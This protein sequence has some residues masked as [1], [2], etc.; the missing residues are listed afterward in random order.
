MDLNT[1]ARLQ[2]ANWA[3]HNSD[4][5]LMTDDEYDRGL[6]ELKRLAPSHPFLKLVGAPASAKSSVILP[7]TMGSQ[8]KVREG[9]GGL[10]RWVKRQSKEKKFIVSEKLDGL[11]ALLVIRKFKLNLYLRGDGV[12]GVDVSSVATKI[13]GCVTT[14]ECIVRG[15]LLLRNSDTPTGSIGRSLVNGWVHRG[16][17]DLASLANV[18]FVAYQVLEPAGLARGDQLRWLSAKGFEVPWYQ[19]WPSAALLKEGFLLNSLIKRKVL[20][21]YPLDGLVVATDSVPLCLGGGEA[22]NPPDSVAYKASLDEQKAETRVIGVEWNLSRQ[23]IWI[24]RIQIEP[25]QSG[26]ATIQ[27]LSGHNA[28]MIFENGIGPGARIVVRRSG[29]VIPTL[30]SVLLRAVGAGPAADSWEWDDH[31]VHAKLSKTSMDSGSESASSLLH[32]F[33]TLGVE[34]IGPGLVQKMVDGGF[35]SMLKIWNAQEKDLAACIGA[36]RSP[37]FLKSLKESAGSASMCALLVASNK[38]PRGVGEKKL[39]VI[40]DKESDPKK[41][42]LGLY[43]MEGWSETT[44]TELLEKLPGVLEWIA[45]SFPSTTTFV[46]GPVLKKEQLITNFV[47]F[48]GVRD[49]VLEGKLGGLGWGMEDSVTKKTTVLVIA[50]GVSATSTGKMKK[51]KDLGIKI[52]TLSAFQKTLD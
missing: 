11:S 33:Q 6:E 19:E 35:T 29:D 30:D 10:E 50:D 21:L 25:V 22:R 5:T 48:T 43:P 40:F 49:K 52:L 37:V 3:Y 44:F 7:M 15:E 28:N 39:R 23:D 26:G 8:D 31:H 46:Q 45:V 4:Q 17:E 42:T 12:K 32:S 14:G 38:L 16:S 24:P 36:G 13:Q 34:G 2:K 47:V 41:W 51:A 1:V 9:E 18:R 20:S 27:W